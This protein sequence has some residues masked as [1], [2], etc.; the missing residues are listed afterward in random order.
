M[1]AW[2]SD[3]VTCHLEHLPPRP[4]APAGDKPSKLSFLREL[5][6]LLWNRRLFP[7]PST[8]ES[9]GLSVCSRCWIPHLLLQLFLP[10]L[11]VPCGK[12][13]RNVPAGSQA[14]SWCSVEASWAGR[15]QSQVGEIRRMIT[16]VFVLLRTFC[17]SR[18]LDPL[19]EQ[20]LPGVVPRTLRSRTAL[21]SSHSKRGS[22]GFYFGWRVV[23]CDLG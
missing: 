23:S 18:G 22:C 17:L 6:V 11:N 14:R 5:H 7:G 20:G 9:D 8:A 15:L 19:E 10:V 4:G 1:A 2:T 3:P 16:P 12:A 13:C 21:F